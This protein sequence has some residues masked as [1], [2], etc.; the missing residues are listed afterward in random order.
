MNLLDIFIL[1]C[2]IMGGRDGYKD[3]LIQIVTELTGFIGGAFLAIIYAPSLA[4]YTF[5]KFGLNL[6]VGNFV[7]F[8]VIWGLVIL[9]M[10]TIGKVATKILSVPILGTINQIAGFILGALKGLLISIPFLVLISYF[11]PTLL[12]SS[13]IIRPF[14]KVLYQATHHFFG[15]YDTELNNQI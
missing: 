11:H 5:S 6:V 1:I 3:G 8:F 12:N 4:N 15:Q 2:L 10:T 7:I 14:Q 13:T 9:C